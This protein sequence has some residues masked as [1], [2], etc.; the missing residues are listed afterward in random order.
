MYTYV[1]HDKNSYKTVDFKSKKQQMEYL[2]DIRPKD[3]IVEYIH[4]VM[5]YWKRLA[6]LDAQ[7]ANISSQTVAN[8]I[9]L[10]IL[11]N[12]VS[13]RDALTDK[14]AELSKVYT[15][16]KITLSHHDNTYFAFLRFIYIR[17][18]LRKKYIADYVI[19]MDDDQIFAEDWVEKLY[20]M[21][22]PQ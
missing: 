15:N 9:H 13:I 18:V 6:N 4:I 1:E 10:H 20:D 5:C 12:N 14:L 7:I 21:R 16:I 3:M 8:R 11:N 19:M 2:R 22:A 17:D